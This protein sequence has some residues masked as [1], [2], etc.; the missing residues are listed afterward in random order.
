MKSA[1]W[2]LLSPPSLSPLIVAG[3]IGWSVGRRT[4]H[5]ADSSQISAAVLGVVIGAKMRTT[6]PAE[7]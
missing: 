6:A 3:L 1:C 5:S 2:Q 7:Q 4:F